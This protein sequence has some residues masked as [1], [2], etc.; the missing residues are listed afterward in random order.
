MQLFINS[1][2]GQTKISKK[3]NW[4]KIR[5]NLTG[6]VW[7]A[8]A[9]KGVDYLKIPVLLTEWA[10]RW[11]LATRPPKSREMEIRNHMPTAF[12]IWMKIKDKQIILYLKLTKIILSTR[13]KK[14]FFLWMPQFSVTNET[15]VYIVKQILC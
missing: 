2:Q 15:S 4:L 5:T 9:R 7:K 8:T 3:I 12:P 10:I 11:I 1:Q 6:F 13:G 14:L